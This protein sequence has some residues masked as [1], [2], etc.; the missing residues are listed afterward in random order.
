M[1]K[2]QYIKGVYKHIK[3]VG[4]VCEL[5]N[6]HLD[7]ENLRSGIYPVISDEEIETHDAS[8]FSNIELTGYVKQFCTDDKNSPEWQAALKHHYD[9]NP[10]HWQHWL[11]D[12][13]GKLCTGMAKPLVMPSEQILIMTADW[14]AAMLQYNNT[15]NISGWLNENLLTNKINL[16]RETR[17]YLDSALRD[18]GITRVRKYRARNKMFINLV[19]SDVWIKK[20]L[21]NR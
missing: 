10:H 15:A 2:E 21:Q 1:N 4:I 6:S 3:T 11:D 5:I 19:E 20:N 13:N 12:L 18:L 9:N 14:T 8:K 16:H 17:E 7:S